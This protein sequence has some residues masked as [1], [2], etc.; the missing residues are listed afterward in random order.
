MC[1]GCR[2][3]RGDSSEARCCTDRGRNGRFMG[4]CG[5]PARRFCIFSA[6]VQMHTTHLRAKRALG[7]PPQ[8]TLQGELT[9]DA[10]KLFERSAFARKLMRHALAEADAI[11]ACSK[12][13][14]DES[15]E[16]LASLSDARGR[17]I[18]SG[19]SAIE[20]DVVLYKH[21]RPYIFAIGRHVA[22]KGFDVLLSRLCL[23]GQD[24][25]AIRS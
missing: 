22:Q 16:V 5:K 15:G 3:A 20:F 14:L 17:V 13:T 19:I 21:V 18:Y 23:R 25:E 2:S 1:F 12:D 11:T 24:A 8:V 4:S 7:P 10:S 9:M 6:S